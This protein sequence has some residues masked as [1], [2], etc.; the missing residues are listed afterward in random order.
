MK[1]VQM[2]GHARQCLCAMKHVCGASCEYAACHCER[3]CTLDVGHA[4]AHSCQEVHVCGEPCCVPGCTD[5]CT[6]AVIN[7][8]PHPNSGRHLCGRKQCSHQCRMENCNRGCS[9]GHDH[10]M[11]GDVH[12]C[13]AV[14]TCAEDCAE[15]GICFC[16]I[17]MKEV[18]II[19]QSLVVLGLECRPLTFAQ[20]M[21]AAVGRDGAKVSYAISEQIHKRERCCIPIPAWQQAHDGGH[22]HTLDAAV[23]HTCDVKCPGCSFRCTKPFRHHDE[24]KTAHGNMI[25]ATFVVQQGQQF[26]V[27]TNDGVRLRSACCGREMTFARTYLLCVCVCVVYI[28]WYACPVCRVGGGDMGAPTMCNIFCESRGR[29]HTHL[30]PCDGGCPEL[31][32]ASPGA[33]RARLS[34]GA[35]AA[36]GGASTITRRHKGEAD[37]DDSKGTSKRVQDE[38]TCEAYWHERRESGDVRG[39]VCPLGPEALKNSRLCGAMCDHDD[40]RKEVPAVSCSAMIIILQYT[41]GWNAV[42]ALGRVSSSLPD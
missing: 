35:A 4:G 31:A 2:S 29:G 39:W 8:S 6:A 27:A 20:V 9:K 22:R 40:H 13:D 17:Q 11:G 38:V 30:V 28:P 5:V 16:S 3:T 32:S 26:T 21:G 19:R 25:N 7:S 18:C 12:Q 34:V 41:R 1:C 36:G 23:L 37:Y 24:H 15:P 14:H 33:K 42:H 10:S